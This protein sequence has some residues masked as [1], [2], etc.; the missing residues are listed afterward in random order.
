MRRPA[1]AVV[2]FLCLYVVLSAQVPISAKRE[3]ATQTQKAGPSP[4]SAKSAAFNVGKFP[5][6]VIC[7]GTNIWV[8]N[9][10]SNTV[11]KLRASDGAV[12]GTLNVGKSPFGVAFDGTNIWVTNEDSN[13]VM[14][15]RASDGA[16][17]DTFTVGTLPLQVLFDGANIWV[18]NGHSNSVS[19]L[20]R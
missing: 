10:G 12:L 16:V 17:L 7:D 1:L 11:T 13:N 20:K 14:K 15:L 2:V 5:I 8:A 9:G 19:K 3:Q 4:D 6:G 18:T